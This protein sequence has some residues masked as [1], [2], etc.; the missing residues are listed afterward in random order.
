MVTKN[1]VE[2][3]GEAT[4]FS[5]SASMAGYLFQSRVALLQGLRLAKRNPGGKISIEKFDDVAFETDKAV[6][7]LIQ[8]KHHIKPKPLDDKS[9]D[10]WKTI[11]IWVKQLKDDPLLSHSTRLILLTTST[12]PP[13]GAMEKL[14]TGSSSEDRAKASSLLVNAAKQSTNQTTAI[15]RKSFIELSETERD[16]LLAL[17]EVIDRSPNLVDMWEEII[18][19]LRIVSPNHVNEVAQS[20]EGWWLGEVAIRLVEEGNATIPVQNIITKASEIGGKFQRNELPVHDPEEMGVADYTESDED[21]VFVKQMRRVKIKKSMVKRS[22]RDYYRATAQR[23]KWARESLLLDGETSRYDAQ[24]RDSWE[25]KR[26]EELT[27]SPPGNDEQKEDFGRR[28]CCWAQSEQL[29]FRN[30]VETWITAGSLHALSDRLIVGWH[31][32]YEE[33]FK[34]SGGED[35]SA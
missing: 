21:S 34:K 12:A 20:L 32:D 9:V 3:V 5:A 15:A 27:L 1:E 6:E 7:C 18:G 23:S 4:K 28:L 24:L 33:I 29:P 25:R 16:A 13:G 2:K 35:E 31:P 22:V 19:E 8:A 30:V 14:R 26:D 10:V 11:R 17:I